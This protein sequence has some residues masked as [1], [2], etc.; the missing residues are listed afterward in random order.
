METGLPTKRNFDQFLRLIFGQIL[1]RLAQERPDQELLAYKDQRT[2]YGAF[3]QQVLQMATALKR[4]GIRKGDRVAALFPN[5]PEF[6]I[7]QQACLYIGAVFVLLSTRYREFK[8]S[9]MLKHSGARCLFTIGEYMNTNFTDLIGKIK[10]EL[11]ELKFVF[12]LGS[13]VPN[14]RSPV[15]SAFRP[16]SPPSLRAF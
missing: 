14:Y 4:L 5:R 1:D 7:M 15:A 9:Y 2:T 10:P 13:D 11:P 12:V 3:Y 6:F 16:P 8:L